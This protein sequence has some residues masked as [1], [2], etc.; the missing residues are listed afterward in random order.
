MKANLWAS[1]PIPPGRVKVGVIFRETA[2]A[3]S[4]EHGKGSSIVCLEVPGR[5]TYGWSGG[6]LLEGKLNGALTALRGTED[7]RGLIPGRPEIIPISNQ[8]S[9]KI[10]RIAAKMTAPI[11]CFYSGSRRGFGATGR[12]G[13]PVQ[14][15]IRSGPSVMVPVM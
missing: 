15:G 6:H 9:G 10:D 1:F 7:R 14:A 13:P 4:R 8:T 3:M 5:P 12:T 2:S 11:R